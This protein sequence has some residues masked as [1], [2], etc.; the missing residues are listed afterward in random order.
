MPSAVYLHDGEHQI[1]VTFRTEEDRERFKA[2][3]RTLDALAVQYR[4]ERDRLREAAELAVD[5]WLGGITDDLEPPM[6]ALMALVAPQEAASDAPGTA[7][8]AKRGD[9]VSVHGSGAQRANEEERAKVRALVRA[10]NALLDA[11][12]EEIRLRLLC[13]TEGGARAGA[14]E[15]TAQQ[16]K[17]DYYAPTIRQQFA[18]YRAKDALRAALA[19]G[20]GEEERV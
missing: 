8:G 3:Y 13:N 6:R 19:A 7:M 14:G 4:A 17:N 15:I 18:V 9:S 20:A 16:Y 10:A 2:H 12:A 1:T 11:E 5:A